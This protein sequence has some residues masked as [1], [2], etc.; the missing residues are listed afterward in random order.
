MRRIIAAILFMLLPLG[1][2]C[3][4]KGSVEAY[5]REDLLSRLDMSV[6]YVFPS[7]VEG[8]VVYTDGTGTT[9]RLNVCTFD[10]SVRFISGP[11]TLKLRSPRKIDLIL[12]PEGTIV[13]RGGMMLELLRDEGAVLLT[14]RKRLRLN[15]PSKGGGYGSI[16]P[17]SSARTTSADNHNMVESHSYG[18]LV[19]VSWSLNS[20][21]YLVSAGGKVLQ[22][23]K[24]AFMA[25][26][27]ELK[28]EI[29]SEIKL[30][31]T[32]FKKKEDIVSLYDWC[33]SNSNK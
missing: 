18:Y 11:D 14:E 24:S 26:F 27:P 17:S 33:I 29:K 4:Q 28:N 21:F 6:A 3:Q 15:E 19:S 13:H 5:S 2:F 22:A 16:P 1:L 7:F 30:R 10:N 20:D 9:A 8:Q 31:K 32:D 25:L 12:T 23:G